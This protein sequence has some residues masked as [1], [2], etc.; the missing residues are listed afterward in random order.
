MR[1]SGQSTKITAALNGKP[2]AENLNDGEG[3]K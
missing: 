1:T 2:V 3:I